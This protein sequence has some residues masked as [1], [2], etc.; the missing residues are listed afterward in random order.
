[1][2]TTHTIG[3]PR[4]HVERMFKRGQ[5]CKALRRRLKLSSVDLAGTVFA[6]VMRM[7]NFDAPMIREEGEPL[8]TLAELTWGRRGNSNA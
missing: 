3:A 7:C 4:S 1:M 6:V 8:K 2:N 5:E